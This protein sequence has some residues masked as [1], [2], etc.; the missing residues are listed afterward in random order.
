MGIKKCRFVEE[1]SQEMERGLD[2]YQLLLGNYFS[3]ISTAPV[4]TF[5]LIRCYCHITEARGQMLDGVCIAEMITIQYHVKALNPAILSYFG[6][7]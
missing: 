7:Y 4:L 1:H 6:G 3:G 5:T 2:D